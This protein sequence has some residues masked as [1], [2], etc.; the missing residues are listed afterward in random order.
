MTSFVFAISLCYWVLEY[1]PG[2][3]TFARYFRVLSF[4]LK[5][6]TTYCCCKIKLVIIKFKNKITDLN[7]MVKWDFG[8]L[9]NSS[10]FLSLIEV[11]RLFKKAHPSTFEWLKLSSPC[12]VGLASSLIYYTLNKPSKKVSLIDVSITMVIQQ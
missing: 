9:K 8:Q 12:S 4:C 10:G 7:I 2:C 6:Q 3:S 11:V 5:S 1:I